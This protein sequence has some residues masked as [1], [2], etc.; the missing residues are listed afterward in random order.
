MSRS[1]FLSFLL[2]F[3]AGAAQAS[4]DAAT[5]L[6]AAETGF[7][8]TM[9]DRDFE[10]FSAYIAEDAVFINGGK[11]LRGKAAILAHWKKFFEKPEPPF[12]WK[13]VLAEPTSTGD[14][15]YTEG[16]VT[17]SDGKAFAT[18]YSTW[19]RDAAG[20]WKVVFDNGY[21]ICACEK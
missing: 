1:L 10:A 17:G 18:F 12:T 2:L 6:R 20:Q 5:E 9:V 7:A 11:P 4:A 13:P 19:R 3:A 14:L 8:Q 16:P 21:P 15:G